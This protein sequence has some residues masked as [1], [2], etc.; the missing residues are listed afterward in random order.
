M[1]NA[2]LKPTC[3]RWPWSMAV[4]IAWM[5]RAAFAADIQ[6]AGRVADSADIPIAH[7]RVY[8]A[9]EPTSNAPVEQLRIVE[10]SANSNGEFELRVNDHPSNGGMLSDKLWVYSPEHRVSVVPAEIMKWHSGVKRRARV[11]LA[12]PEE[13]SLRIVDSANQILGG[14]LVEPRLIRAFGQVTIPEP[15]SQSLGQI[16]NADGLVTFHG[17]SPKELERVRVVTEKWGV[18]T[19]SW[20]IVEQPKIR[21]IRLQN[22]TQI[23]GR[24][25]PDAPANLDNRVGIVVTSQLR[26]A[27]DTGAILTGV[28]A[29]QTRSLVSPDGEGRFVVETI[30]EGVLRYHS[31]APPEV[32][33]LPDLAP[34]NATDVRPA[35]IRIRSAPTKRVVGTVVDTE[36]GA[37]VDGATV[38]LC[39]GA[40]WM[41]A[42]T[43]SQGRYYAKVLPGPVNVSTCWRTPF[44]DIH[45]P[46]QARRVDGAL[47]EPIT[48]SP[49]AIPKLR[50]ISGVAADGAGLSLS[51]AGVVASSE[52]ALIGRGYVDAD[53]RFQLLLLSRPN[54]SRINLIKDG[55]ARSC[56]LLE[57]PTPRL[58][59]E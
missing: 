50:Q 7:A 9:I 46:F 43:D 27:V 55:F 45:F 12:P 20:D 14:Q 42:V 38:L 3:R 53:S 11:V 44:G 58:T 56:R 39:T 8:W 6:I 33:F 15:L 34:G 13:T 47:P 10:G 59:L 2:D 1:T 29:T 23:P 57:E 25:E 18:Q 54:L 40:V 30:A 52:R 41:S 28:E 36:T 37:P 26:E 51:A 16:S 35:E 24:I 49:M 22:V 32:A 17:I 4:L 21:T 19:Q 48:L 5:T 31:V